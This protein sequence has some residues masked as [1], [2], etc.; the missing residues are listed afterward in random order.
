MKAEKTLNFVL[1][2]GRLWPEGTKLALYKSFIRP[3]MDWG[4]QLW[5]HVG[6]TIDLL[7]VTQDRAW[8][9][10]IP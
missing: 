8:K 3:V 4:A 7:E 5:F 1:R 10:I 6:P 2:Q 9:W